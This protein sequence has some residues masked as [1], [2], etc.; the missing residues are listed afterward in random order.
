MWFL[1]C[2]R[3]G[4]RSVHEGHVARQQHDEDAVGQSDQPTAPL[5]PPLSTGTAQQL[6]KG[7]PTNQAAKN[8]QHCHGNLLTHQER[9]HCFTLPKWT[10]LRTFPSPLS[11]FLVCNWDSNHNPSGSQSPTPT[12][13]N[14]P[15]H[16]TPLFTN[17]LKIQLKEW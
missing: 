14:P 16:T 17:T 10:L 2:V 1:T 6:V 15:P 9:V 8:S 4:P 3:E 13:Y 12:P 7:K 5:R 11:S